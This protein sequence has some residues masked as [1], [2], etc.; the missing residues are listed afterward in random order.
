M[1][2]TDQ[3][4][5]VAEAAESLGIGKSAFYERMKFLGITPIREG[6][7]SFLQPKDVERLRALGE[8]IDAT[9]TMEGFG[10]IALRNNDEQLGIAEEEEPDLGTS[11]RAQQY[12]GIIRSAKEHRAGIE[13]AKYA[14][15]SR[16]DVADLDPDLIEQIEAT[17]AATL[18]K[19]VSASAT[20]G[21]VLTQFLDGRI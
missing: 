16:L 8:H 21:A 15:A 4:I 3:K 9:G 5:G 18:P 20:A 17:R 6:R 1:E 10:A 12:A 14:I 11:D 7:Q 2:T 13:M 19:S